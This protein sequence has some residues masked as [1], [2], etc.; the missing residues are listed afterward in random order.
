MSEKEELNKTESEREE[1]F[2]C[3]FLEPPPSVLQTECPI[4]HQIIQDPH[5]VTCCGYSYCHSCIEQIRAN[6]RPCAKCNSENFDDFPDKRL[7]NTL[8][9]FKVHCSHKREGCEWT[10]ELGQ[11]DEHLN[12]NP[13]PEKTLEGCQAVQISC[14]H[15]GEKKSRRELGNHQDNCSKRPISCEYCKEYTSHQDNVI[16]NHWPVCGSFPLSCP[17]KCGSTLQ[18][19]NLESHT[20]NE[21]SLATID[22]DFQHVGCTVKLPRQDMSKHVK[23]NLTV[24]ISLLAISHTKQY[25]QMKKLTQENKSMKNEIE[26]LNNNHKFLEATTNRMKAQCNDLV[27]QNKT[28]KTELK[29][30]RE[31]NYTLK[32]EL[33][34]ISEQVST[35]VTDTLARAR[36]PL[37][38][39]PVLV[40]PDFYRFKKNNG[41]WLS[42][43]V[44]THQ[45][46][47]KL[48]LGV[49]ANGHGAGEGTHVA[50][51]VY[52]LKGE[53]DDLLKWPFRGVIWFRLL[54][55]VKGDEHRCGS[56]TYDDKV[57]GRLCGRVREG[58]QLSG[59]GL[60]RFIAHTKLEPK[61][62]Q[63]DTLH[64]QLYKVQLH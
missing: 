25:D 3:E 7:K 12:T 59:L 19:Q 26:N 56:N 30:L 31:E 64:F 4:C 55:R 8:Y 39:S 6:K 37:V 41:E 18:R 1:G 53:Y 24:H 42:S 15:C 5:Q 23:D 62:L 40:M 35:K 57:S 11:L 27:T 43:A 61:Y 17:N 32:Q 16:Y 29:S 45:Q 47:Y 63:N 50:V 13:L 52:I 28:L 38:P 34:Q 22:C 20:A 36:A 58:E 9:A 46:G 44:Y 48:R 51:T 21:C 49:Y 54:D 2:K 60:N 14:S 10:G 33:S